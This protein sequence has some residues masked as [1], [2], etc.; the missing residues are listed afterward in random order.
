[1]ITVENHGPLIV[2][3]NYWQT[4]HAERGMMHVS[5]NAGAIRCLLPLS[6]AGVIRELRQSRYAVLSRGPWT[7]KHL[8][9]AVE[10][11]WEDGSDAP[12]AWH[13]SPESF[14]ML[15]AEPPAGREWIISAWV[16]RDGRPHR[17][18]ERPCH[19]RRVEKIPW[20][21]PWP[22]KRWR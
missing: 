11:L 16:E 17:A 2:A 9:E 8:A 18:V 3:T 7:D 21:Q 22:S 19:W 20:M 14:S 12:H 6:I 15:P 5:I 4:E 1:M 10:I 13:L